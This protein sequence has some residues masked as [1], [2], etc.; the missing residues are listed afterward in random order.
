MGAARSYPHDGGDILLLLSAGR[1]ACGEQVAE[2]SP[3]VHMTT[4]TSS[5]L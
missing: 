1:C 2:L 3:A 4:T 5:L